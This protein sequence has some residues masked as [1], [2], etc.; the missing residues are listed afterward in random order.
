[1][2]RYLKALARRFA[3]ADDDM[4]RDVDPE[5]RATIARCR[6]FT[7]TSPERIAATCSA[8]EYAVNH[9]LDGAFVECG[10]WKGGSSMAAALTY[11]RQGRSDVPFY[12]Y[13][14]F[15][16]MSAPTEAD[17]EAS[18]GQSAAEMLNSANKDELIWCYST[19]DEVKRN[20]ASTGYPDELT[21]F[22]KGKVE[23][24]I[25]QTIPES[26]AILRLDTDFYESTR[27]EMEHLFP[28]L[29]HGG[30][31]IIDDYGHWAGAR[32]AV[33]EYIAGH[34]VRILLNRTDYTGWIA[35]KC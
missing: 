25:P 28:R 12:L 23:D 32:K 18:T 4:L 19:L 20:V 6:P 7:M 2:K 14:T 30:V 8:V 5:I 34:D 31:L 3:G 15:E 11:L 35:V 29:V 16:G 9:R 22:V 1:M 26:I 17:F 21:T 10:V 13:D 33:D 24:T 27:H